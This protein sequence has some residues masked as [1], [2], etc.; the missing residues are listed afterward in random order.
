MKDNGGNKRERSPSAERSPTPSNAKTPPLASSG[1]PSPPGSPSEV[2]SCRPRSSVFEQGGPS[3]KALVIDLS[4]SSGEEDFIVDTSCDFEF[5]QRLYGELN[6]GFLGSPGNSK[7]IILSDSDE[8]KEEVREEKSS[9]PKDPA[10]SATVNP[11]ST[12]SAGDVVAPTEK[13][14]T[15]AASPAD[16]DED[17]EAAPNDSS[18]GLAPGLKMGKE[19]GCGDEASVPWAAAPRAVSMAGLLQGKQC[20]AL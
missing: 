4:S 5:T 20:S 11:A 13:S 14:S 2:A 16:V 12:A 10:A 1:S 3:R 9:S 19:N 6:R 15:L 8:E 18:D 17:L 7:I